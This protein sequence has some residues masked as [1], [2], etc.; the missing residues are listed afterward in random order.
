MVCEP[1]TRVPNRALT[2]LVTW[3]RLNVS[4]GM[5]NRSSRNGTATLML[6]NSTSS[7]A[8]ASLGYSR[9]GTTTSENHPANRMNVNARSLPAWGKLNDVATITLG[10]D[11]I[12]GLSGRYSRSSSFVASISIG[13]TMKRLPVRNAVRSASRVRLSTIR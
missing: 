10:S 9:P 6:P 12:S 2:T 1:A 8:P 7:P 5:P 13:R 11:S 4:A 3:N